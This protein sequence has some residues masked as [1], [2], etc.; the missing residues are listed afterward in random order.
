MAIDEA[1]LPLESRFWKRV[2]R[3][4]TCWIW[5]GHTTGGYGRIRKDGV[6]VQAHRLSYEMATGL[7]IPRELHIDHLCRNQRCVNPGH[8]EPVTPAENIR[9]G[10]APSAIAAR[11]NICLRGHSLEDA[12]V[13]PN[14]KRECRVCAL[15]A[16]RKYRKAN[17]D[18]INAQ[19]RAWYAAQKVEG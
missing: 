5:K 9:R 13:R 18:K 7:E 16:Q 8:L 2:E 15:D 14:G 12:R 19:K 10:M 1:G 17:R 3:T 6:R 4:E 11:E